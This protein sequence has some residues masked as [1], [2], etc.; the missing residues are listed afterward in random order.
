MSY[1]FG[2]GKESDKDSAKDELARSRLGS[3]P[4]HEWRVLKNPFLLRF[5]TGNES[6]AAGPCSL[7]FI[8]TYL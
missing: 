5:A 4:N 7:I 1:T 6:D 8:S 2:F 3:R